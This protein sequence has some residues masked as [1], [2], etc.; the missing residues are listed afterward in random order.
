MAIYI[1]LGALVLSL[2]L[3]YLL[4]RFLKNPVAVA[5]NSVFGFAAFL[6]LNSLLHLGIAINL[7]SVLIVGFGGFS[8]FI[9]VLAL[10]AFGLAF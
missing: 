1:E 6:L 8:G 5:M 10:H 4:W 7:W 3:L 2:V 9:L